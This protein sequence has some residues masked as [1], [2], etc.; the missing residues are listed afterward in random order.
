MEDLTPDMELFMREE[1]I[2][3]FH[4]RTEGNK[5]PFQEI[6]TEDIN[7]ALVKLLDERSHPGEEHHNKFIWKTPFTTN[8]DPL[9]F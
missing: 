5:E 9:E 7:H 1:G 3:I 8:A 4:Y 2:Q 6:S